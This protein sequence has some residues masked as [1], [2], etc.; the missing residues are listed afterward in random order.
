LHYSRTLSSMTSGQGSYTIE[1][2]S[3]DPMPYSIQQQI[4]SST[5]VVE[6]EE[7]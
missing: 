5:K 3:Y 2:S 4:L 6:E 7:V 1:F